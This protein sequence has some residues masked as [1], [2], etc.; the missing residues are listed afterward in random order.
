MKILIAG[1]SND[2]VERQLVSALV[3]KNGIRLVLIVEPNSQA[4]ALACERGIPYVLH[5]FSGRIDRKAIVLYRALQSEH[6]FDICHFMTNRALSNGILA[7]R[8]LKVR[9]A[10]IAYRGT[11]GHLSRWDPASRFSYLHKDIHKIVCV[12]HSVK[13]YLQSMHIPEER[14]VVIPKGH[15]PAWYTSAARSRLSIYGVP[16]DASI[17]CFTGN[18]RPVKGVLYLLQAFKAFSAVDNIHLL[19]IGEVR[20]RTVKR[21][22]QNAPAFVHAIGYQ[23]DAAALAGACDIC[24]MPSIKREG[25][26]KAVIEC[27]CQSVPPIVTSV[28]GLPELVEDGRSGLVVPPRD[29]RALHQAIRKLVLDHN[30]RQDLGKGAYAR[31]ADV[32]SF[33]NTYEKTMRLYESAVEVAV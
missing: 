12:S 13:A 2:L 33:R 9:P 7:F 22:L 24:V 10:V 19:I 15:D 11:S 27:M 8:G 14:L 20:D 28:G 21:E 18:I 29:A 5:H 16:L 32:F 30:L 4:E 1:I 6:G 3:G 25:L 23:P 31:V 26:P 17:I